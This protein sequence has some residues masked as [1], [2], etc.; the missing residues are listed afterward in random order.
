M[1]FFAKM[2]ADFQQSKICVHN[3]FFFE[4][5]CQSLVSD[6]DH[7]YLSIA[8]PILSQAFLVSTR[9][10]RYTIQKVKA[11][12]AEVVE[13]VEPPK[14]GY[15]LTIRLNFGRMPHGKGLELLS[16]MLPTTPLSCFRNISEAE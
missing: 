8:T 12:S 11:I 4:I 6:P 5:F 3:F 10:S 7:T 13:I 14:E 9:L 15:Q 1:H 16:S 2:S